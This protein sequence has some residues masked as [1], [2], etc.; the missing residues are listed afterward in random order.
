[1]VIGTVTVWSTRRAGGD[2]GAGG[3]SGKAAAGQTAGTATG[4]KTGEAAGGANGANA[5]GNAN[6]IEVTVTAD[7]PI[8]SVRAVGMKQLAID[9]NKAKLVVAP[10]SGTRVVDGL[11][12]GGTHVPGSVDSAG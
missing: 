6:E 8:L 11:V 9:G 1:L 5:N 7:S 2:G 3:A 10:W 12:A 4:A